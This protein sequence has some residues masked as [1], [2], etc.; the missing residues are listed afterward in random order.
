MTRFL[1]IIENTWREGVAKKTIFAILILVTIIIGFLLLAISVAEDTMFLFGQDI[2][3]QPDEVIR[4]IEAGIVG[5]FYQVALFV[6]IFAI[7]S[8]Y[9][10]MQEKGTIDLLL[11]RPMSRF[12]I[13]LAKFIGC[14]M[15]VFMLVA[16]LILGSWIVIYLKTGT[17]Y[18]E[19]LYTIP[20]FMTIFLAFMSF[21]A[22]CGI[23]F[24]NTTTSAVLAIFFP[25]L[26]SLILYG[27]H[28]SRLLRGNQFW[29]DFFEGIYWIFPKTPELTA[30]NI[31]LIAGREAL[32]GTDI[33]M[34]LWTSL[35]FAAG[36]FMIGAAVFMRRSY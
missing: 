5:L 7:A 6:G 4:A 30:W 25:F 9:P 35:A 18:I 17:A 22:M 21:I 2:D 23:I 14:M 34:A 13:Y 15:V 19:F 32:A 11:S 20:I 3:E 10:N 24:R 1:A 31:R 8:F 29:Y 27:F 33:T 16:Y 12:N 36:T 28:E 26:F